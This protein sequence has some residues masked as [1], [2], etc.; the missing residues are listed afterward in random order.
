MEVYYVENENIR[1]I[2]QY[3]IGEE[4]HLEDRFARLGNIQLGNV[5]ILYVGRQVEVSNQNNDMLDILGIDEDGNT[6]I[7]E[8]KKDKGRRKVVAQALDYAGRVQDFGY[9]RLNKEYQQTTETENTLRHDH[10]A[11]FNLDNPLEPEEF[12]NSQRIV[13][14]G[15]DFDKRLVNMADFLREHRIDVVLVEYKTYKDTEQ[16]TELLTT[17]AIRRPLS[18]EPTSS[19]DRT[20]S[21]EKKRRREFW[22]EFTDI[23]REYD[24]SGV[25]TT[26]H[27]ASYGIY[28]FTSSGR[29]KKPAYIRPTIELSSDARILIRFYDQ[30]F[31]AEQQNRVAFKEAIE[32]AIRDL[33]VNLPVETKDEL[34]W[35]RKESREFDKVILRHDDP[36]HERFTN[37]NKIKK[38]QQWFVDVARVYKHGLKEMKEE[39]RISET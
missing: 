26:P 23:Y 12:N 3:A 27:S 38:I 13:L 21:E 28:I 17:S 20:I 10:E 33:N 19:T 9:E 36:A 35:D 29:R 37:E 24:L 32:A 8:L 4:K 15:T 31:V 5:S 7:V 14:V 25:N 22:Q 16:G 2:E 1:R 39:G 34:E 11:Q 30:T 18:E 6:V